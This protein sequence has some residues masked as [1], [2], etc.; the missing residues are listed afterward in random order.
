MKVRVSAD[1]C[2]PP[3]PPKNGILTN[4]QVSRLGYSDTKAAA[5]AGHRA[6]GPS[7]MA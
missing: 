7:E 5:Y 2:G 3:D 1:I 4:G 6:G